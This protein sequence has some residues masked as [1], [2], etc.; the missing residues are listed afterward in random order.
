MTNKQTNPSGLTTEEAKKLQEKFDKNE[1]K[2]QKK[3]S[4]FHKVLHI[5]CKPMF[6]LLIVVA[7]IYFILGEQHYGAIMLVFVIHLLYWY[8]WRINYNFVYQS[9]CFPEAYI[10]KL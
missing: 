2:P 4:Y 5:I 1:L 7:V 3:K 10:T 8:Y 6:L 9:I